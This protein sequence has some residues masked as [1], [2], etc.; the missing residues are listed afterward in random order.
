MRLIIICALLLTLTTPLLSTNNTNNIT[1]LLI[2]NYNVEHLMDFQDNPITMDD[3]YTP[4]GNLNWNQEKFREKIDHIT[5]AII[6]NQENGLLGLGPDIIVCEEVENKFVLKALTDSLNKQ[7]K[8]KDPLATSYN[9]IIHYDTEDYVGIEVG[10]ISRIPAIHSQTHVIHKRNPT[11]YYKKASEFY[12]K[13]IYSTVRDILEAR[14]SIFDKEFIILGNHW[15][16]Q[17]RGET[18]FDAIKRFLS[19]QHVR[20]IVKERLKDEPKL[21]II[22]LGD[23]NTDPEKVALN[24]GL[25][26]IDDLKAVRKSPPEE[27]LLYNLNYSIFNYNL[28]SK[29]FYTAMDRFVSIFSTTGKWDAT[30]FNEIIKKMYDKRKARLTIRTFLNKYE[31]KLVKTALTRLK[32]SLFNNL[33]QKRGTFWF[34]KY[35]RWQTLDSIIL[36]RTLFDRTSLAYISKSYKILDHDFLKDENGL[37]Y[38]YSKCF[39]DEKNRT[40]QKN[41]DGTIH[42]RRGYSDH[43]PIIARFRI[44]R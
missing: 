11:W 35:K 27:P 14:F 16:A 1:S 12:G 25:H 7:L 39:W 18:E 15:P 19:A 26:A 3:E 20:K 28:L 42:I 36:T 37:P 5:Q 33:N 38:G 2:M 23:F 29:E 31:G 43:F 32:N 10:I 40:C 24:N 22:I 34:A 13:T 4:F 6:N 30:V 41:S 9:E 44:Y 17:K 21:D 8:E